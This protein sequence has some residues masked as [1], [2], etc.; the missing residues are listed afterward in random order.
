MKITKSYKKVMGE[1]L[2][3]LKKF[4]HQQLVNFQTDTLKKIDNKNSSLQN[5]QNVSDDH[6]NNLCNINSSLQ[7]IEQQMCALQ[8]INSNLQ[9]IET[10]V[11]H[12]PHSMKNV[13]DQVSEVK[14]LFQLTLIDSLK[15]IASHSRD[16][17]E[18]NNDLKA[19]NKTI[20]NEINKLFIKMENM[21]LNNHHSSITTRTTLGS[22]TNAALDDNLAQLQQQQTSHQQQLLNSNTIHNKSGLWQN[23]RILDTL[24]REISNGHQDLTDKMEKIINETVMYLQ[25]QSVDD[26]SWK[27]NV[28]QALSKIMSNHQSAQQQSNSFTNNLDN[29]ALE[30][31]ID[32]LNKLVQNSLD[33]N[34]EWAAS[35][36][37]LEDVN[38]KIDKVLSNLNKYQ[39]QKRKEFLLSQNISQSQNH[40]HNSTS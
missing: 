35:A 16:L 32:N 36:I 17:K 18:S 10:N 2:Q 13:E 3:T 29:I 12:I 8:H 22:S 7:N 9:N 14:K 11:G 6:N 31:K 20:I 33:V 1:Y 19:S 25:K 34:Q 37:M 39:K 26:D 4:I 40:T 30:D 5:H 23:E 24:K 28:V 38:G 15:N 27:E 21:S